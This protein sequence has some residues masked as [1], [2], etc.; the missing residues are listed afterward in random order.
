MGAATANVTPQ[1]AARLR[2]AQARSAM[3]A[4]ARTQVASA[5]RACCAP[6]NAQRSTRRF[7]SSPCRQRA[8][9]AGRR[10]MLAPVAHQRLIR[11]REAALDPRPMMA[12]L[13]GSTVEQVSF[14]EAK[15]LIVRYEW[16]RSMPTGTRACYGLKTPEGELA[17]VVVFAA[18]PA[19]ESGD[20]CG[21]EHREKT[22]CLARGA[23]VHWAHPHAASFLIARACRLAHAE[24]GWT[25]FH[26]Y[27][28]P[29]AGERGVVYQAA[30]WIY[31]GEGAGRSKGRG[32]LKFFDRRQSRWRSE[33]VIRRRGLKPTDLRR[34]PDWIAQFTPDKGRYVWF[35][36]TR[37]EKRALQRA[38]KYLPQPYPKR[39]KPLVA[40]QSPRR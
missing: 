25:V 37:R 21:P 36:G 30:N 22:I 6:T 9:R 28:D 33:R 4:Y 27:A 2:F 32:R 40:S 34:H 35:E 24:F 29:T 7:C 13:A 17:G 39:A 3:R 20:L 38:L 31:L 11:E 19:P 12:T 18:G 26:A 14:A 23:G 5:C 8:Y 16:L 1:I 15:A 10:P